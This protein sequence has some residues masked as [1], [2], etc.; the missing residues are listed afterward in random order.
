MIEFIGIDDPQKARWPRREILYCN[1]ANE[2]SQED[3]FQLH[4]RTSYK[5]FIDFNPDDEDI[6]I[7][8]E[9]EQK[10][11]IQGKDVEVIV[12]TYK[13]NPFL[14]KKIVR[15]IE[16]LWKENEQYWQIYGLGQYGKL[17]GL[18]FKN[19]TDIQTVPA[20]AK[21]LWHGQDFGF[22]NDPS[23]LVSVYLWNSSIILDERIYETQLNNNDLVNRYKE[24]WIGKYEEIVADSSEPKSI[25]EIQK[26]GFNIR[27]ATKWP[28]SIR[29]GIDLMNQYKIY[30]TARSIN[31]KKEFRK[32][33]WGK[34][35][36]GKSTNTPVD[37][38][39][40]GID[41]SRYLIMEKLKKQ[42]NTFDI[43]FW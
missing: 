39:N 10:R 11:A 25:D 17:E 33:M 1:E 6:W 38:D 5:T 28:D 24:L 13:D 9:L 37:S 16:R 19:I 32:Y 34:D 36:N 12:S 21:L 29:F 23:A 8:T 20:E 4:I 7:N 22:T 31:L 2:L 30:V 14:D 41:A 26:S 42:N 27:W 40:H 43:T 18:I 15:E 3:F 35:K